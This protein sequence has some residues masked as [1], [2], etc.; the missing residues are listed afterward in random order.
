MFEDIVSAS[1]GEAMSQRLHE[2]ELVH[3]GGWIVVVSG[4]REGRAGGSR[5]GCNGLILG[6]TIVFGGIEDI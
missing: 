5:V 6:Y 1:L 2:E 4:Q 3:L